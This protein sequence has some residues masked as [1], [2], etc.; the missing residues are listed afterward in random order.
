MVKQAGPAQ[1]AWPGGVPVSELSIA[2]KTIGIS[3]A[4][5]AVKLSSGQTTAQV[6]RQN[7]VKP[8]RVV[9]ALVSASVA[10]MA[11][12]I[13]QGN[14]TSDQVQRLVTLATARAVA[15]ITCTFPALGFRPPPVTPPWSPA[16]PCISPAHAARRR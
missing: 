4:A 6:A 9:V 10:E 3:E 5:L 12:D 7:G 13:W 2:A 11:A 8:H 15:Q 14:L 1:Q 16:P